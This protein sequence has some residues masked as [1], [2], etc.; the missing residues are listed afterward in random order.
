M[1][2]VGPRWAL[3]N[4]QERNAMN[5]YDLLEAM[6]RAA[7]ARRLPPPLRVMISCTAEEVAARHAGDGDNVFGFP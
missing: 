1:G 2:P 7:A 3:P 5:G 6:Q 4:G